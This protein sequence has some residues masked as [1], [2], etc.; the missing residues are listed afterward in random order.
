MEN[1]LLIDEKLTI[2]FLGVF[3]SYKYLLNFNGPIL[4]DQ[5]FGISDHQ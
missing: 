1:T 5:D 3:Y 4:Y 2:L